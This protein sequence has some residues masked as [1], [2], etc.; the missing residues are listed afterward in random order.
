MM[1]I[2]ILATM[3]IP[4]PCFNKKSINGLNSVAKLNCI[5]SVVKKQSVKLIL[6]RTF[7]TKLNFLYNAIT[8]KLLLYPFINYSL[9]VFGIQFFTLSL[10]M[11]FHS[12]PT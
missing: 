9:H 5:N 6:R 3:K 4:T 10:F 2:S 11:S 8:A 1:L 7:P 12:I